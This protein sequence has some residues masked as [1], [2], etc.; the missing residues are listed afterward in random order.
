MIQIFYLFEES[1]HIFISSFY[2]LFHGQYKSSFE[3]SL[4]VNNSTYRQHHVTH[5]F[6]IRHHEGSSLLIDLTQVSPR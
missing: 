2:S 3:D 6:N 5:P 1:K 4:S